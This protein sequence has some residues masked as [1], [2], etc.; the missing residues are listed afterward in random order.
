LL[1][2]LVHLTKER[3]VDADPPLAFVHAAILV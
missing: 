3:L 1:D 2:P